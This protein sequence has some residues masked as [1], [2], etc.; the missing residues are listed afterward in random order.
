VT[1]NV[2]NASSVRLYHRKIYRRRGGNG[3]NNETHK[4]SRW[5][6]TRHQP[7]YTLRV[8]PITGLAWFLITYC[9]HWVLSTKYSSAQ[10]SAISCRSVP[11][12]RWTDFCPFVLLVR[13]ACRWSTEHWSNHTGRGKEQSLNRLKQALR[14]TGVWG[15]HISWQ[16]AHEGGKVVSP[17]QRPPLPQQIFLILNYVRDWVDPMAIVRLE[18][19]CQWKIPMTPMGIEPATFHTNNGL[20]VFEQTTVP[21]S[22]CPA[23]PGPHGPTWNRVQELSSHGPREIQSVPRSEYTPRR[24]RKAVS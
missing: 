13:A 6:R 2:G 10:C 20:K 5:P 16:S 22:L 8:D 9:S 1:V 12:S 21:V 4:S 24:S 7:V 15:F 18:G 3:L 14:L 19:L 23:S 11:C 17:T